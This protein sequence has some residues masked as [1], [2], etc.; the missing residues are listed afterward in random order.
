KLKGNE[1]DPRSAMPLVL[2]NPEIELH[3]EIEIGVEGCLSF[4]EVIGEIECVEW[5]IVRAQ[6]L[7][8][9]V[10]QFEAGACLARA[11]RHER[12]QRDGVSSDFLPSKL[13]NADLKTRA[14]LEATWDF[15][16]H[17]VRREA[18]SM[19]LEGKLIKQY[20]PRYKISFRD[21]KRFLVVRVDLSEEWPRF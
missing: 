17:S 9:E 8:C 15:E 5:V 11:I 2:I 10:V 14:L 4:P 1:V 16:T 12:D 7:D 18:E 19:L 6:P 13:A 3:G 20:R 21:D